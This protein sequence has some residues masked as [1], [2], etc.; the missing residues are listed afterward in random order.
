[1]S[2]RSLNLNRSKILSVLESTGLTFIGPTPKGVGKE[3]HFHVSYEDE[4]VAVLVFYYN[5]DGTTT[6]GT[7]KG[8]NTKRSEELAKLIS[9]KC[10]IS[11]LSNISLYI[12]DMPSTDFDDAMTY[13]REECGAQ[14]DGTTDISGGKQYKYTGSSGDKLTI[15]YFNNHAMQVQGKP[16]FL[17]SDLMEIL[18]ELLP[19]EKIVKPQF[20]TVR[21]NCTTAEILSELEAAL[22]R[23]YGFLHHKTKAIISPSLAL[24]RIEIDL[25]DYTAFTMPALRGLE[26]YLK[27]LFLSKGVTVN[28]QGFGQFLTGN[29]PDTLNSD[30]VTRLGCQKIVGAIEKSYRYW[31]LNRHG[32]F[33]VDGVVATT[34]TVNRQEAD[35]IVRDVLQIIDESHALI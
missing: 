7:S 12:K 35:S 24:K 3:I 28:S 5:N 11:S 10:L 13:L 14:L 9:E 29:K 27:Q 30:T 26:A 32:L 25:E 16:L 17:Y 1:M 15:K 34:R 22:P 4:S 21:V 19:Y 2:Y 31:N 33:H 18:C 6:I 23:A 8:K 20:E